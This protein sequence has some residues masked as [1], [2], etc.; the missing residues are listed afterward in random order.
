MDH[1]KKL[2]ED[3]KLGWDDFNNPIEL[4]IIIMDGDHST[5]MRDPNNRYLL[6]KKFTEILQQKNIEKP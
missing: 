3:P 6:G 5:M 1:T 4:K 2:Y